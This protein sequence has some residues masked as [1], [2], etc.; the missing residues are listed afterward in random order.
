MI[1]LWKLVLDNINQSVACCFSFAISQQP[2]YSIMGVYVEMQPLFSV[3]F[4]IVLIATIEHL[5]IHPHATT[6]FPIDTFVFMCQ[7]GNYK[8]ALSN[9]NEYFFWNRTRFLNAIDSN[10][11]ESYLL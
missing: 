10:Q 9:V 3:A 4:Q 6:G 11:I 2:L 8:F 7:I 5:F 1:V